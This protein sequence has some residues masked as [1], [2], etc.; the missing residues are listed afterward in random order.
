MAE[1]IGEL[2]SGLPTWAL[3]PAILIVFIISLEVVSI[4][5]LGEGPLLYFWRRKYGKK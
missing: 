5:W 3:L 4:R 2:L 1:R